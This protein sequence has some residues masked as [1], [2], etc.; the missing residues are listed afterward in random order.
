[1]NAHISIV[2]FCLMSVSL[3]VCLLIHTVK[4]AHHQASHADLKIV[5]CG[6]CG[7]RANWK[8]DIRKHIAYKHNGEADVVELNLDEARASLTSYLDSEM[9]QHRH[10][11]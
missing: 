2:V 8:W 1:M 3:N 5:K 10:G 6:A 9:H 11:P 7:K 4:M